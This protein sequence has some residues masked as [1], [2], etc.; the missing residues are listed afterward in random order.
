MQ[1][2]KARIWSTFEVDAIDVDPTTAE[3]SNNNG[4]LETS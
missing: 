2:S 4:I 1:L 3:L